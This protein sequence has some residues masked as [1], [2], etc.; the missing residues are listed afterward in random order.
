MFRRIIT[1]LKRIKTYFMLR[2][3]GKLRGMDLNDRGHATILKLPKTGGNGFRLSVV[4]K[5]H[6]IEIEDGADISGLTLNVAGDG[7]TLRVGAGTVFASGSHIWLLFSNNTVE[8]GSKTAFLGGCIWTGDDATKISIG[9][10]CMIAGGADIRC[11]DGHP[12]YDLKTGKK[13][14][15]ASHITIGNKVWLAKDV[16]IL[17][18]VTIGSGSVVGAFSLV[19]RDAPENAIVAGCPAKL[20]REGIRWEP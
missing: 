16:S 12:I 17:K 10:D 6:R 11:G 8:I 9:S 13:L 15:T 1:K 7:N 5:G 14:N 18:N 20:I 3:R 2:L 4:G 19:T